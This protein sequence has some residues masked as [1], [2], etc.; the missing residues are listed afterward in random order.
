MNKYTLHRI[1]PR[2]YELRTAYR[3]IGVLFSCPVRKYDYWWAWAVFGRKRGVAFTLKEARREA[4]EAY[5]A[6]RW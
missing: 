2:A 4:V 6:P 5:E 3:A 1:G